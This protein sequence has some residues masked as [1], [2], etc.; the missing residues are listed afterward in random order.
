MLVAHPEREGIIKAI[1]HRW[2]TSVE[3]ETPAPLAV[4]L[5]SM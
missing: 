5:V 4:L 3:P 1:S 2:I